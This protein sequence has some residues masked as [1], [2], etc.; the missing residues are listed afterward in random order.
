M[1]DQLFLP[2]P[3]GF[4]Q[5]GAT[6]VHVD[7]VAGRINVS[8]D[9]DAELLSAMLFDVMQQREQFAKLLLTVVYTFMRDKGISQADLRKHT[10]FDQKPGL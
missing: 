6:Y 1:G 8:M 9:G 3:G 10:F 4:T 2:G 5:R 7:L